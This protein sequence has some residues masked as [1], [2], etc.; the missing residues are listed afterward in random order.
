MSLA[1]G[2]IAGLIA[3]LVGALAWALIVYYANVQ[4]GY[5]ALG[6]GALVGYAVAWATRGGSA[7]SAG[8]SVLLTLLSIAG[9]KY[10]AVQWR[11]VEAFET[12]RADQMAEWSDEFTI[13][14][15][16]DEILEV[17]SEAGQPAVPDDFEGAVEG[18]YPPDVWSEAK[19]RWDGLDDPSRKGFAAAKRKELEREF[20]RAMR[21][22]SLAAITKNLGVFDLVFFV[23]GVVTAWQIAF[24]DPI[25]GSKAAS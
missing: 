5:L 2:L 7:A 22:A 8:L 3:A 11:N 24:R 9:G 14:F 21:K 20:L 15:M 25:E 17:R 4:L 10:L 23:L 6:I 16:A 18:D 1:K 19:K 13:S 12:W